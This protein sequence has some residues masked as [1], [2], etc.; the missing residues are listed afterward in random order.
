VGAYY[1]G[2]LA[3][4]YPSGSEHEVLF[5]CRGA[6]LE[7]IRA[8]GLRVQSQDGEFTASPS[9]ATDSVAEMGLVD[10]ALYCTKGYD[11]ASVAAS[12]RAALSSNTVAIPL[13]N[14]VNNDEVLKRALG[15]AVVLNGCVYISSHIES[16]GFIQQ[17]GGSRKLF[18]GTPGEVEAYRGIES[19]LQSAGIDATL[20]GEILQRVWTKYVFIDASSGVTSLHGATIGQML[21]DDAMRRQFR[22]LMEEV[23]ALAVH[24]GVPLPEDV[25]SA[26]LKTAASFPPATKTSMQ[27]DFEFGRRTELDVMLGYIVRSAI[28]AGIPTPVHDHVYAALAARERA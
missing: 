13:G 28:E 3:S 14:G 5:F 18:F 25:V 27:L 11:L 26:T 15:D 23:V 22:G 8:N 9:L 16:P 7:A 17:T 21:D 2:R 10:V 1:G 20:T 19:L 12:T 6:H 4:R 24:R